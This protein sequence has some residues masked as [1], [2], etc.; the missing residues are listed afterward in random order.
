MS[1]ARNGRASADSGR[2]ALPPD[3]LDLL[4]DIATATGGAR[5]MRDVVERTAP[6]AR[7]ALGADALSIGLWERETGFLRILVN[8]GHRPVGH[9]H[10]PED[11]LYRVSD[12]PL[13]ASLDGH[14][15]G[16]LDSLDDEDADPAEAEVL[17]GGRDAACRRR[18]VA[19]AGPDVGR[20]VRRAAA[21][22]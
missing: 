13:L 3:V 20:A 7:R 17:R 2:R 16:H 19:G 14:G 15:R 1:R 6:F 9:E 5:T 12:Y 8:D 11:E 21:G 22:A 18:S 10:F 4:A